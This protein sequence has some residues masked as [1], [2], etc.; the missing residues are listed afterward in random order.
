MR[1]AMPDA[2]ILLRPSRTNR[3][4]HRCHSLT[5]DHNFVARD[6][7]R[8]RDCG[9]VWGTARRLRHCAVRRAATAGCAAS[10]RAHGAADAAQCRASAAADQPVWLP[11]ALSA[12]LCGW[13]RERDR[14]RAQGCVAFRRRSELPYG[15]AGRNRALQEEIA[16]PRK[17]PT[18]HFVDVRGERHHVLTWGDPHATPLVLLHGWMDVGASFQFLVDA[19]ARDWYAIAPDLRGFGRFRVAAK[20]LLVLR[21]PRGSRV[22]ARPLRPQGSRA[23]GRPQPRRQRRHALRRRAT[24]RASIAS[25]RSRDSAFPPKS[26][27]TRRARSRNGSTRS[28]SRH[29]SSPMTNIA[30]VADRLQQKNPRLPRDMAE[31]LAHRWARTL[32]DGRAELNSDPRHKM[33]FPHVYRM[34]ESIAIWRSVERARVVGGGDRFRNSALDRA[35]CGWRGRQRRTRRRA[36]ASCARTQWATGDD[37]R[38]RAHAPSRPAGRGCGRDRAVPRRLSMSMLRVHSRRAAYVCWRC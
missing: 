30:A 5:D 12:R 9:D 20:R 32:P 23:A 13:L 26:P 19:L 2:R 29:G 14:C 6:H 15:L 11:T 1:R 3:I 8:T 21:L 16:S 35:Q 4:D 18:S 10:A 25:C 31:F 33:P 28:Q 24:A 22:A 7:A 27:T 37:Q 34:E 38:C 36:A 17:P